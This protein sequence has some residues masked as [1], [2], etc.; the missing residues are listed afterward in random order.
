MRAFRIL[1]V[2]V[3][4]TSVPTN[5]MSA[6]SCSDVYQNAT[7]NLTVESRNRTAK[8]LYFNLYCES[9]GDV[10]SFS[11]AGSMKFPIE[12][13]PVEFGGD[14][15]WDEVEIK[16]FCSETSKE[17]YGSNCE[18][19][20]N[21]YVVIDAL[22]LYNQC[23][24]LSQRG[25]T[26]TYEEAH[27]NS[28]IIFGDF[29]N[30][31]DVQIQSVLY[32]DSDMTCYSSSF[33]EDGSRKVITGDHKMNPGKEDFTIGCVRKKIQSNGRDIFRRTT[34]QIGTNHGPYSI[35][36]PGE[37]VLGFELGSEALLAYG[38]AVSERNKIIES[39]EHSEVRGVALKNGHDI[40]IPGIAIPVEIGG[41]YLAIFGGLLDVKSTQPLNPYLSCYI[42]V[43][44][45]RVGSE[46]SFGGMCHIQREISLTV[47]DV[48][49][50]IVGTASN[51]GIPLR[52]GQLSLVPLLNE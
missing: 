21:N 34:F 29:D 17:F 52:S 5:A 19:I 47:G 32:P 39:I 13:I 45:N 6:P 1:F 31:D 35:I 18:I 46:A 23:E 33:S 11:S 8:S 14:N 37:E 48:V 24:E 30:R 40:E 12:G 25:L 36:L 44:E 26:I 15:T 3:V 42:A 28:F 50:V 27:P 4:V 43:N 16:N 10:K 49:T 22:K 9:N 20:Y 38:A 2:S 7:R 41:S 51:P